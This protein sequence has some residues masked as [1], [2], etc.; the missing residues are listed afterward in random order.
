M[1]VYITQDS[2]KQ[3]FLQLRSLADQKVQI[4]GVEQ[5]EKLRAADILIIHEEDRYLSIQG[6]MEFLQEEKIKPTSN[7][8]KISS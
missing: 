4:S 1:N 7:M 6:Y 2:T 3:Y 5:R 8:S